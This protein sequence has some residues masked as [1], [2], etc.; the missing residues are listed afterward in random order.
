MVACNALG[1]VIIA[2]GYGCWRWTGVM[3]AWAWA[4]SKILD[5][6]E[7]VVPE[8]DTERVGVVGCSRYGKTALA[9]AIFDERV[10]FVTHIVSLVLSRVDSSN[11]RWSCRAARK[12]SGLGGTTTKAVS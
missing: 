9:A 8:V 10:R 2:D 7:Q 1:D 12:G 5:A 11:L 6:L 4:E 3:T